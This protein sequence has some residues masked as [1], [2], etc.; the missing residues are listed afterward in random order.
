M[1]ITVSTN[2][3]SWT[4]FEKREWE[5]ADIEHYGQPLKWDKKNFKISAYEGRKI[6]GNLRMDIREGV[7]YVDAIIVSPENR[8]KGVGN[9]LMKKAEELAR[10]NKTHKIYL[11][12]GEDWT[13]LFFY[14][15]LGYEITSK[16]PNHY[17]HVDFVE[18][19]KYLL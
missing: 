6:I 2:S 13:S 14:L 18:L 11:Q 10:K 8:G 15:K 16:L 17:H 12:T 19:T 5:K 9:Q 7:A 4:A 1:R 3:K